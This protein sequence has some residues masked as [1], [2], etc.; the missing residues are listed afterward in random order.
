MLIRP[1]KW[2]LSKQS[3]NAPTGFEPAALYYGRTID[4]GFD[5]HARCRSASTRRRHA[6]RPAA[7]QG[8]VYR[9]QQRAKRRPAS[10]T[11]AITGRRGR[12]HRVRHAVLEPDFST[13]NRAANCAEDPQH[14]TD[15]HKDSADGV[16]N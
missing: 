13:T 14:D 7:H 4:M 5:H 3:S 16:K 9:Q 15:H 2:P 10:M 6:R 11:F 8:N 12:G 1:Q